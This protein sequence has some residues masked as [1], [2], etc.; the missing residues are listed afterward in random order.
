MRKTIVAFICMTVIGP[1][2]LQAA[3]MY[4]YDHASLVLM[5]DHV[6]LAERGA[7]RPLTKWTKAGKYTIR[8]AYSGS[9]KVGQEIE[10][11]DTGLYN[12]S[13]K[14]GL[15]HAKPLDL[16]SE[17]VLF[18]QDRENS[19]R[20]LHWVPGSLR[21]GIVPSGMRVL[22]EGKVYRFVQMNNP[23]G[24]EPV[25]QGRD[26]DDCRFG[27]FSEAPVGLEQFESD[28]RRARARVKRLQAALEKP[29][30]PERTK[31]LL[32]LVGP[33]NDRLPL[34]TGITP[35]MGGFYADEVLARIL[36]T[37]KTANDM[38]GYVDAAGRA[39]EWAQYHLRRGPSG[40]LEIAID[41]AQPL[42][43][44]VFALCLLE[45][46][47]DETAKRLDRL[48]PLLEDPAYEVR[49]ATVNVLGRTLQIH[50]LNPHQY[51][52]TN[53][54]P[55]IETLAQP[56]RRESDPLVRTLVARALRHHTGHVPLLPEDDPLP[57]IYVFAEFSPEVPGRLYVLETTAGVIIDSSLRPW[58][59]DL[60]IETTSGETVRR[61]AL[62]DVTYTSPDSIDGDDPDREKLKEV[63][64]TTLTFGSG[65][66]DTAWRRRT[67]L[68]K[69]PL[70][71]GTY[72][73][74]IAAKRTTADA[75]DTQ[76]LSP[77]QEI[78][79]PSL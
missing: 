58:K 43:R 4:H 15:F 17:T 5:S 25:P 64:R 2:V 16:D 46:N 26:P 29:H 51:R 55:V 62:D 54:K 28:L 76:V 66:S 68:I 10:V 12:T 33:P 40:V 71:A 20:S 36:E 75:E 24:F 3:M 77:P 53:S 57:P 8:K 44:R 70:T 42:R 78:V 52:L 47:W 6:V 19:K 31:E 74:F 37:F 67:V 27:G 50:H 32:S 22:S 60:L 79:V 49:A 23:G 30:S 56:W 39:W 13:G 45:E 11:F 9:L 72:R 35:T 48:P 69:P 7:E 59:E 61:V 38:A 63:L 18:L 34:A 41:G 1:A 73:F 21:F 65:S 14:G